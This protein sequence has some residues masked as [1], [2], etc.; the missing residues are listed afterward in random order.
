MK[1]IPL[2][3]S[4]FI[5]VIILITSC[6]KKPAVEYTSTYKMSGEW[7]IEYKIDGEPI[8]DFH[9][10]ITYNTSDPNS[11][12]IWVDDLGL[13][14]FVAKFDVDYST[15]S[16]KPADGIENLGIEGKT[17]KVIEGKVLEKAAHSKSGNIVDSIY[18]KLEFSD[19]PGTEYE[20]AG[21]QR[22][23]F[24]EDEY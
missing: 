2:N 11:G 17:I 6:S 24:F 23:G 13:W 5:G 18:M 4:I 7:F 20:V 10:I 21:H 1:R 19:D 22:T 12:K 8:T 15:L 14:P 16:F 9:K 3:I